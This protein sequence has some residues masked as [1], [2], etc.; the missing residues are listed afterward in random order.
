VTVFLVSNDGVV[1][2]TAES[3]MA[4]RQLVINWK[5]MVVTKFQVLSQH[6]YIDYRGTRE[7]H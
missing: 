1:N 2:Q 7:N 6:L 5:E 3:R 4:G